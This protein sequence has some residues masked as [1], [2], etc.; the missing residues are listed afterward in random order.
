MINLMVLEVQEAQTPSDYGRWLATPVRASDGHVIAIPITGRNFER[1]T[2]AID[3]PDL[4]NDPRFSAQ[5][6]REE[7]WQALMGEIQ[8]WTV[9]RSAS[10]VEAHFMAN[11]VPCARYQTVGEA[12][13][14]EHV[15][16]RGLMATV[17]KGD[18]R[19]HVPNPPFLFRGL[20]LSVGAS[21]PALGEHT[22]EI[23]DSV[24]ADRNEE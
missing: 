12:I 16:A 20:S 14:G 4:R 15:T 2:D 19:F 11:G 21:V 18:Y 3:R 13:D 9:S 1:L 24:S 23:L 6:S 5:S 8:N 7:N 22:L 17:G 10:E